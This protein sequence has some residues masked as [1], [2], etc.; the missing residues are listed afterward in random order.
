[1]FGF[2][3]RLREDMRTIG[4]EGTSMGR[5]TGMI[6]FLI[7][8]VCKEDKTQQTTKDAPQFHRW[9]YPSYF[10]TIASIPIIYVYG[11]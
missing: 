4:N 2:Q 10:L 9:G 3:K 11:A 5:F 6:T 7:R 1:M 8:D